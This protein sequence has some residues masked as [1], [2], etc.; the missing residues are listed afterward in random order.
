MLD[1]IIDMVEVFR[2]EK[3]CPES[4]TDAHFINKAIARGVG[5]TG[6]RG[7]PANNI[8]GE[9]GAAGPGRAKDPNHFLFNPVDQVAPEAGLQLNAETLFG[10]APCKIRQR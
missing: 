5:R 8:F 10:L 3:E 6:L 2:I 4:S 7:K 1:D 9:P